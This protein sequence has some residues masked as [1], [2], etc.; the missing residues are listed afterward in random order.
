M[1]FIQFVAPK[2]THKQTKNNWCV[3]VSY[4][5]Q[6]AYLSKAWKLKI[7]HH[8][9]ISSMKVLVRNAVVLF[10]CEI[11]NHSMRAYFY[12]SLSIT[13]LLTLLQGFVRLFFLNTLQSLILQ[14]YDPMKLTQFFSRKTQNIGNKISFVFWLC[15]LYVKQQKSANQLMTCRIF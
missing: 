10:K 2:Q 5:Y 13:Q 4:R 15:L 6:L 8:H 12:F 9:S 11:Y 3:R 14:I 1:L 7:S